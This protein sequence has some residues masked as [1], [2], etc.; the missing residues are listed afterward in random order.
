MAKKTDKEVQQQVEQ[1]LR[2]IELHKQQ[3]QQR[4]LT[5][6]G[7]SEEQIVKK[8]R[9]ETAKSPFITGEG[10]TSGTHPGSPATYSVNIFN[11]DPVGYYPM[12]VT[13]FFGLANFFGNIAEGWEGRDK[14]WPEL[15]TAPF[16]ISAGGST[17]QN[18]SYTVPVGVPLSTYLGEAVVWV[19]DFHDIGKYFDRG[20]FYVTLF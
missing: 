8:V 9:G 6:S 1:V 4:G 16:S 10:W 2:E 20:F 17:T 14:R 7:L 19:G 12:F 5:Y 15:S 13:I 11:P 3:T 18:F